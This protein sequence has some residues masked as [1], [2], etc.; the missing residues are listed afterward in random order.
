METEG[1]AV[2]W[3][4]CSVFIFINTFFLFKNVILFIITP[5]VVI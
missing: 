4:F 1:E 5:I 3:I 2:I